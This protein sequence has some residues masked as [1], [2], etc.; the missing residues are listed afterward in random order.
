MPG[1]VT[2]GL[3]EDLQPRARQRMVWADD[4]DLRGKSLDVG[5]V[6]CVPSTR[7]N[8]LV[9]GNFSNSGCATEQWFD[10]SANG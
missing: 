10:W 5:S 6:S 8:T 9:C 2:V 3:A 7:W 4:L 1:T